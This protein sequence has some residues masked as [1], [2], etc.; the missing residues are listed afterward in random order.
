MPD[1][2][3]PIADAFSVP[4]GPGTAPIL[5]G[6]E[7]GVFLPGADGDAGRRITAAGGGDAAEPLFGFAAE[8]GDDFGLFGSDIVC[9]GGVGI[10]VVEFL[11]L[12]QFPALGAGGVIAEEFRFVA[13]VPLGV[14]G[15]VGPWW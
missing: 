9:F 14:Q 6:E 5:P 13:A 3:F 1:I 12:D 7:H 4:T 15:A 2:D 10:E 8:A 11:A